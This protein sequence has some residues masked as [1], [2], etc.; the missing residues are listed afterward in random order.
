MLDELELELGLELGPE[1]DELE[2]VLDELD[3]GFFWPGSLV[4]VFNRF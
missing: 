3:L 1:L 4:L 2:L